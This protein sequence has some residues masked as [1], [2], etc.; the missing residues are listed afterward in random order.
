MFAYR[1]S[2]GN[3][4]GAA[5]RPFK[6]WAS[7]EKTRNFLA[8]YYE[9]FEAKRLTLH[10]RFDL[11]DPA[12][13]V[14]RDELVRVIGD[15][16]VPDSLDWVLPSSQYNPVMDF[17]LAPR[18]WPKQPKDPIWL[19]FETHVAWKES[20]LPAVQWHPEFEGPPVGE[21]HPKRT[22]YQIQLKDRGFIQFLLGVVIPIPVDDPASYVFLRQFCADAPFKI[23][24]DKFLVS[25][26]VGN[27][28]KLAFRKPNEEVYQRLVQALSQS[29]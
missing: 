7:L 3:L 8:K 5:S 12:T 27:K 25:T 9:P 21:I 14:I 4:W 26:P 15:T 29:Q 28:G 1:Q 2:K 20:V 18:P 11:A 22:W 13:R 23:N 24:P 17:L 6:I 16:S 19:E 10:L